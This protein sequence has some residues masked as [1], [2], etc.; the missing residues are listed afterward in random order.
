MRPRGPLWHN[1]DFLRLWSAHAAAADPGRHRLL[2]RMNASRRFV[3]IPFGSL[4]GGALGLADRAASDVVDRSELGAAYDARRNLVN[5]QR[6]ARSQRGRSARGRSD[7]VQRGG[8]LSAG[9]AGSDRLEH[10]STAS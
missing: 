2:G 7:V 8:G 1:R 6:Q 9:R 5:F 3:V 10:V 4:L